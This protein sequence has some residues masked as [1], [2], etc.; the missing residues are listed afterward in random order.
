M[1]KN[2]PHP[3]DPDGT[4]AAARDQRNGA[5]QVG[6][7]AVYWDGRTSSGQTIANGVYLFVVKVD[8]GGRSSTHRGKL[9]HAR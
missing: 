1:V 8:Q 3:F 6:Q 4:E 9:V 2:A 5:L 7:N